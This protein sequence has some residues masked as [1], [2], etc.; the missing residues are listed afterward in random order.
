VI[1]T[2][3]VDLLTNID[4]GECFGTD[5]IVCTTAGEILAILVSEVNCERLFNKERD[6]LGIRRYAISGETMR[7]MM[8]LK[9]SIK[10]EERDGEHSKIDYKG[11]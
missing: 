3:R 2:K 5:G 1:L 10:I 8:L 4:T 6:L 11:S 9:G 7:I